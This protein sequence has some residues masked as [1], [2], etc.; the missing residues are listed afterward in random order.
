MEGFNIIN[1]EEV[2]ES[3]FKLIGN[4]WMLITAGTPDK[5]NTMTASWGGFGVLWRKKVSFIFVRPERYTY[6]FLESSNN[7]TLSFFN[8]SY[9]EALNFCGTKSGRDVDKAANTG[10]TPVSEEEGKV[11]FNEAK[12]VVV[13]KKMYFQDFKPENFLDKSIESLYNGTGYHRMYVGEI[14]KCYLNTKG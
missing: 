8:E 12:L 2:N 4:D 7:F 13:C 14:E 5:Y 9:R 3:I 6:E 11:F 1:P 10:I